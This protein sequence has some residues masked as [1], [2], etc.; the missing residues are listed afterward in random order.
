MLPMK[1]RS[2]GPPVKTRMRSA[3]SA[4]RYG[5]RFIARALFEEVGGERP[6]D[7]EDQHGGDRHDDEGDRRARPEIV[8]G[9][10]LLPDLE[11]EEGGGGAGAAAGHGI[12]EVV[13]REG[14]ERI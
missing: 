3:P 12:D 4:V 14:G 6:G 9:E 2:T 10:A 8:H 5:L 13:A 1:A 7:H 11:G